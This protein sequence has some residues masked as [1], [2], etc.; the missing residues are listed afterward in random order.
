MAMITPAYELVHPS[1]VIP[2]FVVAYQQSSGYMET[3]ATGDPM[4]RLG[5]ADQ[6]VYAKTIDVRTKV[7]AGQAA[8]NQLPSADVVTALVSTPTYLTR[9]RA[10]YDHHDTAAAGQWGLGIA[11]AYRLANRQGIFQQM[12]TGGLFGFNPANG[13][14][15]LNTVGATAVNL[16]PDSNGNTT[17]QTYD[18]G[19]MAIFLLQ[20]ILNIKTRMMQMGMPSKVTVLGPQRVIG[21]FQMV[22]IVQL[23]QFQRV[24]AGTATTTGTVENVLEDA[25]DDIE[26]AYDDTLINAGAGGTTDAVLIVIPEIKRPGGHEIDTNEFAKVTPNL[27]A[28]TLQ[29]CDMVAPREIPTPIPGGAIDV[30]FELRTTSGWGLRPE[31]VTIVSMTYS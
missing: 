12:R 3:L 28:C 11:D 30:L 7:N 26:W 8:Y 15:L 18:N 21:Q 31:A 5:E 25:G 23:T 4:V 24:G 6:Y 1:Y 9:C 19:Q 22:N 17:V 10:E 14:G 2:E 27:E 16:P 13:E 29:L 20:Q